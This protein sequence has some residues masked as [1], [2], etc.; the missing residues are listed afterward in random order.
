MSGGF[1]RLQVVECAAETDQA[2]SVVFEVPAELRGTF[3]WRAGQHVTVRFDV[4][5]E[6]LRRS[7]SISQSPE[8][9][10]P[11]RITVKRVDGGQ[12]SNHINDYVRAGDSTDVM[13]AFGGFC[14]DAAAR[15][16][17]THYF[18]GAGSGITPL[19]AMIASVLAAE[20]HSVAHLVYGNRTED[21]IIFRGRLAALE[22]GSGGRLSVSHVLSSPPIWSSIDYW[23][24]GIVDADAVEAFINDHPPYA[25]DTQYYICGPGSM[26]RTVKAALTDLNVPAG[27]IHM[28]SYGGD[29]E[30]DMSFDGVAARAEIKINGQTLSVPVA[31]GQSVLDAVR[32]GGGNPDYSCQSGVCGACRAQ[33]KGGDVHMRAR[34]ALSDEEI[35]SGAIL[36][37]Q[38]VAKTAELSI[39][40]D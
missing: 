10:D 8:T 15:A 24:R 34:M 3:R 31:E 35:A 17:R 20:P 29:V 28:E 1:H 33:L 21:G 32:A 23:R 13:P 37:C 22:A 14:L 16:R 25:Q 4:G 5:G 18:F 11:L 19:F 38:A 39:A 30:R 12:V 6:E 27:R 7:Y 9:G 36:T 26:N 40:Y 2:T